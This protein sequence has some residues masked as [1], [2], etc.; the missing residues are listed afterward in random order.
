ME[1]IKGQRVSLRTNISKK[2]RIDFVHKPQGGYQYFDVLL[3]DGSLQTISEHD[4]LSEVIVNTPW[5]LLSNN[6][7][8]DYRDFSIATTLHKV[9]NTTSNTISSLKAS[10]TIFYPYQY[11]PLVKFLKSDTKRILIADEV[12]LGKTIEAG[13]ILLELAARGNLKNALVICSKSLCDKWKA[14]L[15]DKFNFTFKIYGS[16]KEYIKDVEDDINSYKRSIFGIINYER[17]RNQDLQNVIAT[18]NYRFDLLICD[19][20]HRIRNSETAQ[21]KGIAKITEY[22]EAVVFMTATPVM[23]HLQ[24]LHSLIRLLDKEAYDTYSIFNNAVNQ[25]RPFIK[26]LSSLNSGTTLN[27]IADE[28]HSAIVPQEMIIDSVAVSRIEKSISSI[29]EEDPLYKRARDRMS[30]GDNSIQNRILIQ[31]DLVELNSLN[32]LYTRTRKKD[33]QEGSD[34]IIREARTFT[35]SLTDQER[36]IYD[37][38]MLTYASPENLG[39]MTRKRQMASSIVASQASRETLIKGL[40]DHSIHDSK[41]KHLEGILNKVVIQEGKKMIIFA[42][43]KNTLRYLEIK[44][45]ELGIRSEII[46][47]DVTDRTERINSFQHNNSVKVLLSSEVGSEGIDLQFC[48]ALVNYDLPWNPMV[49]E[50]RIGRIDR[51]GQK[52]NKIY[53]F[54]L[55]I[56][57]TIEE[58]IY[59]RLYDRI[60]LFK[61]SIGDLEEILGE[62]ES[63]GEQITQG[64]ERLYMTS[65]TIQQQEELLDNLHLAIEGNRQILKKIQQDL[66]E[67]FA[68]DH[69]FQNE[70]RFI[71]ENNRYLTKVEIIKYIESL[72]RNLLSTLH[73][74]H[75]NESES[76]ISMPASNANSLLN[77][78]E[79]YKDP[80]QANP[81]LE[82]MYRRFK[83]FS[84]QREIVFTFDQKYAYEHKTVEYISAFHPLVN[85]ATN[86]FE[87]NG[88]KQNQAHR[89][90]IKKELLSQE[91]R[92]KHG[93]YILAIYSIAVIKDYGVGKPRQIDY[94]RSALCDINGESAEMKANDIADHVYGKLQ[95]HAIQMLSSLPID[96]Q[97]VEEVRSPI[98]MKMK[99]DEAAT[100]IDEEVR[101]LSSIK[102]RTEQEVNYIDN[103]LDR[104]KFQLSEGQGIEA[105]LK[106]N[107]E[108][109]SNRKMKLLENQGRS[110]ITVSHKLISVNLVQIV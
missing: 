33:V 92:L 48:D 43:F 103:R 69:H 1:F 89:V 44:L 4:L 21:H 59:K 50:Q 100:K 47:G 52:S 35:V 37:S 75:I 27:T 46:H 28:L 64:I 85:A 74:E 66:S 7:L 57:D 42:F 60:N 26:A 108:D 86:Y 2:G 62:Q 67:A 106:K 51:V 84:G 80:I 55:V 63:L 40:Y 18:N 97:F 82:N 49:V 107:L 94:L 25:N 11:K 41:F 14:E 78:I 5:D 53:I 96:R 19:E 71:T 90:A 12:G 99:E 65:L 36:Q 98:L 56:I 20:A 3:D 87:R 110:D 10:R 70:I 15:Q 73:I 31:N 104:L 61:E 22:S 34:F 109:L 83:R 101:F 76:R 45:R 24:N 9:R 30:N 8:K 58:R 102:R 105:I 72:I 95:L 88:F 29:F 16:T 68:N 17:C 32:Y 38:V 91:Y 81:E 13:H 6:I 54:N 79:E 39:L 93:Y 23:T 77:F